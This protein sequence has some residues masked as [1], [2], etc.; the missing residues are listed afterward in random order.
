MSGEPADRRAQAAGPDE[1]RWQS[2]GEAV[3]AAALDG[4][5]AVLQALAR[6]LADVGRAAQADGDE[7]VAFASRRLVEI[8]L[9]ASGRLARVDR[10]VR[11]TPDSHAH[12]FLAAVCRRPNLSNAEV[13]AAI[14]VPGRTEISRVGRRLL[15]LGLVRRS[16][17]GRTNR[18]EATTRVGRRS[19]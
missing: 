15:A 19:R 12:R 14:D 5:E 4:D 10:P 8:C 11:V 18:W 7:V 1:G 13:G 17:I 2:L 3:V 9:A 6:L 16:R